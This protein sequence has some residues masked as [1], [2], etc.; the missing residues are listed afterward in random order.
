MTETSTAATMP[1]LNSILRGC[2]HRVAAPGELGLWC[3][4]PQFKCAQA[5]FKAQLKSSQICSSLLCSSLL[6]ASVLRLSSLLQ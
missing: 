1:R 6:S 3:R 5:Q 4:S 2:V